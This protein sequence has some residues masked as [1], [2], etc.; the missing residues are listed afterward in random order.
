MWMIVDTD[1]CVLTFRSRLQGAL[2]RY[3]S[4]RIPSIQRASCHVLVINAAAARKEGRAPHHADASHSTDH[5]LSIIRPRELLVFFRHI[6]SGP[7]HATRTRFLAFR[8]A[9]FFHE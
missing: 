9:F 7:S 8:F 6:V 4:N 5:L 3:V 2:D 1:A